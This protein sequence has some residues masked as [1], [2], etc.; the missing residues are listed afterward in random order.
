[1]S[2]HRERKLRRLFLALLGSLLVLKG[3][4][5]FSFFN[6]ARADLFLPQT[7]QASVPAPLTEEGPDEDVCR[8]KLAGVLRD[9][10]S[11]RDRLSAE[12]RALEEK[13]KKLAVY[14]GEIEE[15]VEKLALLRGQV[16]EMYRYV[17]QQENEKQQRLVKIYE[18]MEPEDAA[19]RIEGMHDDQGAWLLLQ[20]NP[21]QAGQVLGAMNAKTAS[22]L[23]ARLC[24][25]KANPPKKK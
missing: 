1:M 10:Q 11:E 13:Q 4:V 23:T 3:W 19:R 17:R 20:I 9:V 25:D 2:S 18:S 21:R 6:H 15:R 5:L 8:E 16:E 24:P 14:A 22:R 12:E 7:A